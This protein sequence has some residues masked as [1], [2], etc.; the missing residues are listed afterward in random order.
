MNNNIEE[1]EMFCLALKDTEH[2]LFLFR[3]ESKEQ[4]KIVNE[5]ENRI[6]KSNVTSKNASLI[7]KNHKLSKISF[8]K[9]WKDQNPNHKIFILY[10]LQAFVKTGHEVEFCQAMNHLRDELV[11]LDCIF[12]FGMSP[13]FAIQLS[14]NAPDLYSFFGY[15]ANFKFKNNNSGD[16]IDNNSN[17]YTGDVAV[18]KERLLEIYHEIID[19]G[20]DNYDASI[21]SLKYLVNFLDSWDEI[22]NYLSS[23]YHLDIIKIVERV[24]NIINELNGEIKDYYFLSKVYSTA[25]NV[26]KDLGYYDK[27]LEYNQKALNIDE[28]ILG[29]EHLTTATSYNNLGSIYSDLGRYEEALENYQKALRIREKILGKEHYKTTQT[30]NSIKYLLKKYKCKIND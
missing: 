15:Q 25:G 11:A 24:I 6:G 9:A 10:N 27:S 3:A 19:H 1:L 4:D 2:G 17:I 13:Y 12:I 23:E 28:E 18:A 16:I 20:I 14:Q 29:N 21:I 22:Y 30:K 8:F 26:Y 5:I 7:D